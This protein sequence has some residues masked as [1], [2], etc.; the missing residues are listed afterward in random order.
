MEGNLLDTKELA[1]LLNVSVSSINYYT[2]LGFFNVKDTKGKL[3]LYDREQSVNNYEKIRQ[4][5]KQGYSL[6]LIQ[7]RLERGYNI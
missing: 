1:K 6:K 3:R 4:L 7:Q 2:N 5:R